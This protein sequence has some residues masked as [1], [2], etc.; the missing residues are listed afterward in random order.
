MDLSRRV[1]VQVK[2]FIEKGE[3]FIRYIRGVSPNATLKPRTFENG[4][5][6]S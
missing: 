5:P 2:L 1:Y 4:G 3:L 6:P